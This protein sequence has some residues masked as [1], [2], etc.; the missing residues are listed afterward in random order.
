MYSRPSVV[1][2]YEKCQQHEEV[3]EQLCFYW[4]I[5]L[6]EHDAAMEESTPKCY[7][8]KNVGIRDNV[9]CHLR[10]KYIN[11]FKYCTL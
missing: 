3:E 1:V 8:F 6:E 5:I 4:E 7:V 9:L 11:N 2:V 10:F